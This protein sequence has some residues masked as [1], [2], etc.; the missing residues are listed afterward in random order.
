MK[1]SNTALVRKGK[2]SILM[3][4]RLMLTTN[5]SKHNTANDE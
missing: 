4:R 5:I 1:K 2:K 3:I